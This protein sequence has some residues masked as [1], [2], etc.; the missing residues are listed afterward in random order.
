M[1]DPAL[2]PVRTGFTCGTRAVVRVRPG[3]FRVVCAT[4][5]GGGSVSYPAPGLAN[6]AAVRD[7]ARPC[8]ARPS[9]G[10]A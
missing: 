2:K 1:T 3:D 5:E 10:A 9:C 4:C 7:S 6:V 8:P